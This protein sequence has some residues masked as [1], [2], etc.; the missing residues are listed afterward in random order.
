MEVFQLD[1]SEE[2]LSRFAMEGE[3]LLQED[4]CILVKDDLGLAEALEGTWLV[5]NLH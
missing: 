1:S 5:S 2:Q 4:H 3:K